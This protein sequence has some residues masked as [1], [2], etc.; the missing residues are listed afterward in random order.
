VL[1]GLVSRTIPQINVLVVG[2]GINSLITLGMVAI[3]LGSMIFVF[4]DAFQP[5]IDGIVLMLESAVNTPGT[6]R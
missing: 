6:G 3:S 4:R 2:F 5:A 1:L